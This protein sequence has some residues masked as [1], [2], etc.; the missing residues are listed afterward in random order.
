MTAT[1]NRL[2]RFTLSKRPWA[3]P[4]II[5]ATVVTAAVAVPV[6]A[7]ADSE[8]PE[9]SPAEVLASVA[10]AHEVPFA[11][12]VVHS[13]DLGF[14]EL[15]VS[16]GDVSP[17]SLLAGAT[18][19]RIWYSDPS[20][21]RVALHGDLSETDVI[22]NDDELWY[23][24]SEENTVR[25]H[26][27]SLWPGEGD[28]DESGAGFATPGAALSNEA[29]AGLFLA[30]LTPTSDVSVDG[31]ASVA[32]RAA[33]ELV[34]RPDDERSLVD[35]VRL[36]VDGEHGVPLRIQVLAAD[37]GDPAVEIGFTSVTFTEP[38]A[39]VYEFT[40][41]AG[42]TVEEFDVEQWWS[43][44]HAPQHDEDPFTAM[45]DIE[46]DVSEDGWASVITITGI[47]MADVTGQ[48]EELTGGQGQGELGDLTGIL[49]AFLNDMERVEG[50]YGSGVG[51]TSRLFSVLWLDDG[52]ML[53]G[54]VDLDVL[55]EAAA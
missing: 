10:Q 44:K 16:G 55:E 32:G 4:A 41:P 15:P 7:D 35:S 49:D 3:V 43:D 19:A 2:Q 42:A 8:L 5:T 50:P 54:A 34:I 29:M 39:S 27:G 28:P 45:D 51:F 53:I 37:G 20:S 26:E 11:G 12:T 9:K 25:H 48:L 47:E 36:A 38:E 22:V 14:P 46:V 13:A 31:T 21:F 23:W 24:N 18:T 52:R 6:F 33:Y 17:L 1:A 30:W 40:P